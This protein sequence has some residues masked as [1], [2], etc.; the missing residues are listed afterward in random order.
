ML[1]VLHKIL[2][3]ENVDG[4]STLGKRHLN[5]QERE[6][7]KLITLFLGA[8][9]AALLS[10]NYNQHVPLPEFEANMAALIDHLET[11]FSRDKPVS[12]PPSQ[13]N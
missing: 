6:R 12:N 7:V 11:A 10:E 9:D 3:I 5:L 1:K 2:P 13:L 4:S 8:N